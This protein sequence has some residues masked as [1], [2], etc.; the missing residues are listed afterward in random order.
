M[1]RSDNLFVFL[2]LFT[3]FQVPLSGQDRVLNW[4]ICGAFVMR[5]VMIGLGAVALEKCRPV[6]LVCAGILVYSSAKVLIS[7]DDEEDEDL[8]NNAI[9]KFSHNL[10][11][12]TDYFDGDNFFTVVDGV[13]LATPLFICMIALEISD[14]VFAVDSIPAVFGVTSNPFIIFSSNIFAIMGLRSLY[15]ILSKAAS[16]ME[17]LEPA[18]GI[19]LGFIGAKMIVE[20]FGFE[21]PIEAALGVVIIL[22]SGGVGLSLW[23]KRKEEPIPE[24]IEESSGIELQQEEIGTEFTKVTIGYPRNGIEPRSIII[25][26]H[27]IV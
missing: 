11:K 17:Y 14:I 5:A 3:Y 19:V 16:E 22:L 13:K 27:S 24:T 6:L 25:K 4:G 8:K 12:S 2:L 26:K 20:Y 10:F 18:V 21:I 15:T 9:V 1:L 7:G 23:K